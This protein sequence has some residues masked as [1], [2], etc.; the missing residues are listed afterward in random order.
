ME[1]PIK[2]LESSIIMAGAI[3][4]MK[5]DSVFYCYPRI[6]DLFFV[7]KGISKVSFFNISQWI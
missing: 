6:S 2:R 4:K 1:S 7:I 5:T 3:F